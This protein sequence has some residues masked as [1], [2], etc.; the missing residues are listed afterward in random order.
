MVQGELGTYRRR[1]LHAVLW[2]LLGI[3]FTLSLVFLI[4]DQALGSAVSRYA[5]ANG[6][7]SSERVDL[8]EEFGFD[9]GIGERYV[10]FLLASVSGDWGISATSGLP[11]TRVVFDALEP[12]LLLLVVAMGVAVAVAIAWGSRAAFREREGR[13]GRGTLLGTSLASPPSWAIGVVFVLLTAKTGLLP[14][15]GITSPGEKSAFGSLFD[16]L[17]HLVLPAVAVGVALLGEYLFVVREAVAAVLERPDAGESPSRP[18]AVRA[19]LPQIS[20]GIARTFGYAAACVIVVE[21]IFSYPGVGLL[22]VQSI[23][24]RDGSVLLGIV[25]LLTV[26]CFLLGAAASAFRR[27]S[28][29]EEDVAE[30][31]VPGFRS[32]LRQRFLLKL[33][34]GLV[35]AFSLVAFVG[36]LLVGD[37]EISIQHTVST[38]PHFAEPSSEHLLGTDR[39]GRSTTAMIVVGVRGAWFWA[40][41]VALSA[42]VIGVFVGLG[43]LSRRRWIR[44]PCDWATWALGCVPAFFISLTLL[45]FASSYDEVASP[46]LLGALLSGGVARTVRR[47]AGPGGVR[48]AHGWWPDVAASISLVTGFALFYGSVVAFVGYEVARPS[49]GGVIGTGYEDGA[50]TTG[51]WWLLWPPIVVLTLMIFS[52]KLLAHTLEE[53]RLSL[54]LDLDHRDEADD[55]GVVDG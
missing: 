54:G 9:E 29:G 13:V 28:F 46:L 8:E 38:E 26:V 44:G 37:E 3:L 2:A 22:T 4:F 42:G 43:S 30:P 10:G 51:T 39:F 45:A 41:E 33:A 23:K 16:V 12:T 27:R 7:T 36:P 40:V 15:G 21:W 14:V 1:I 50:L 47:R 11:V 18:A 5:E 24:D 55:V 20:V 6:L 52:F 48:G 49:L 17:R 32:A 53:R 25:V 35:A 19:A 34:L 31:T